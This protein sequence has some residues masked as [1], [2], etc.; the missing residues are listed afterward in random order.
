MNNNSSNSNIEAAAA[1]APQQ[2][3]CDEEEGGE[4]TEKNMRQPA[5]ARC[6]AGDC[7]VFNCAAYVVLHCKL[8]TFS[9]GSNNAQKIS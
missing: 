4:R 6:E 3:T 2:P 8:D 9:E 5:A 7:A 1:T